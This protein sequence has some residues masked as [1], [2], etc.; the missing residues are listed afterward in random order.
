MVA[1]FCSLF[2]CKEIQVAVRGAR[3][4]SPSSSLGLRSKTWSQR[5]RTLA[6][7]FSTP[8]PRPLVAIERESGSVSDI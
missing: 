8:D 4:R 7:S 1:I 2:V 6:R 5:A 3:F